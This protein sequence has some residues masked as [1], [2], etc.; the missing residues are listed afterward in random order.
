MIVDAVAPL[1][2]RDAGQARR[3]WVTVAV[4]TRFLQGSLNLLLFDDIASVFSFEMYQWHA[5]WGCE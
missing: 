5:E 3:P 1:R 4:D 2:S